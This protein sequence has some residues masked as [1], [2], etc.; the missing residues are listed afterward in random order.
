MI[1]QEKKYH[2]GFITCPAE[3]LAEYFPTAAEP[4]LIPTEPP[5]TPDDQIAVDY[6]RERDIQVSP[7]VWGT[8]VKELEQFD[9]VVMRSPWDF[10]DDDESI[11]KFTN[12]LIELEVNNIKI[13][14]SVHFMKWLLDKSYLLDLERAGV[15][16][17]PSK[18]V[19]NLDLTEAYNKMG[20]F[21]LK[22]CVSASGKN[23]FLIDSAEKAQETQPI[24]S[25]L[26]ESRQF[27]LQPFI[28]EI[29]TNGEWSLVFI[30]GIYCFAVH[31]KPG[32]DNILVQ[33]EQGGSTNFIEPPQEVIKFAQDNLSK[34]ISGYDPLYLRLDIL[35][36]DNG[37]LLSEC[38]GVEP[39]LFFRA[40]EKSKD[41]FYQ[42][43]IKQL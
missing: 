35:Q 10:V 26:S 36:T 23:L 13:L 3:K 40:N 42:A 25:E 20:P 43:L 5:F 28:K 2:I 16:V 41:L 34:I 37:L 14:N 19:Q 21:V 15:P 6:L 7:I 4:D 22:P 8:D 31:K 18:L 12:W 33:A 29:R 32:K 38:E 9:L 39:E 27:V 17:V 24:Y 11:S 1:S 30:D